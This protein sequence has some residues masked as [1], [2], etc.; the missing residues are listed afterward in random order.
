LGSRLGVFYSVSSGCPD[1]TRVV[2][3]LW[4][5]VAHTFLIDLCRLVY[6]GWIYGGLDLVMSLVT[7]YPNVGLPWSFLSESQVT[8]LSMSACGYGRYVESTYIHIWGYPYS[9]NFLE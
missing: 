2:R 7:T 4:T 9:F 3:S 6:G 8:R 5:A 1:K